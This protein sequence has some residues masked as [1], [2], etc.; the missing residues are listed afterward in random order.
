MA[1]TTYENIGAWNKQP[2]NV[3]FLHTVKFKFAIRKIPHCN[4]FLKG[5]RLPA[6]TLGTA[7]QPTPFQDLPVPGIN[8]NWDELEIRFLVE[9]VMKNYLEIVEWMRGLGLVKN[10]DKYATLKTENTDLNSKWGG[11]W[12]DAIL[13]VLTNQ[14]NANVNFI[15]RDAYPVFL[16]PIEFLSDDQEATPAEA[17]VQ[18]KY[19]YYD[20]EYVT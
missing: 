8:M 7:I 9:E 11:I 17:I 3:N 2:D 16:S 6:I 19:A 4:Y 5:A 15:F 20:W 14:A 13:H 18:F 10:F 1:A 12:S